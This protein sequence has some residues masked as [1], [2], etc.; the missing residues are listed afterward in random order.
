MPVRPGSITSSVVSTK[1]L[2]PER[3]SRENCTRLM[4]RSG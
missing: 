3:R 2:K 4:L 1:D